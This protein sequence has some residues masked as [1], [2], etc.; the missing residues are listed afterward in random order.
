MGNTVYDIKVLQA[1]VDPL[2]E[3]QFRIL[4]DGKF[5]K[6]LTIDAKLYSADDMCFEPSLISILPPL[7]PGD[8]NTGRISWNCA[9]GHPHFSEVTKVELPS[10]SHLWHPLQIDHLGL[11]MGHK[12]R[13]NVYEASTPQLDLPIVVKFARFPSEIPYLDSETCAY[14]WI[15]NHQIGPQFLGHLTEEGRVIGFAMERI[16]SY[17][18]ATPEDLALCQLTLSKL[19]RLSIKHGD[20]NKH[21]FLI[22]DDRATLIDFDSALQ[23][24]NAKVLEEEF[25]GL[26]KELNDM[27]GRGGRVVESSKVG[28]GG[29]V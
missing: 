7:P 27:S 2:D 9:D 12:L 20:I 14:Q 5:V 10:I 17:Q 21:N 3:S 4:V 16:T 1:S 13:S 24:N 19:H 22:H 25:R 15:Q 28:V 6:Y 8:W 29:Y 18:H 23:C 11:H 26:E